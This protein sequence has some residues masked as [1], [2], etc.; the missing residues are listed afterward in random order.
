MELKN[1]VETVESGEQDAILKVL[2]IYNQE[3]SQC[4]TFEDEEREER[5]KM[6]HLLI[7]FLERELQPSC[8]V[9]CLESIRILSRDKS[10]LDPFTTR[11]GLQTLARHAGI[12]YSEELI[13]EVPDLD[14]ILEALKC[15]CNI[16][17]S[18]PRAQEL[19]A[20]ARLVVGLTERIKLYNEKNLPHEVRFFDLRLLF[21]LTAL[22]VDIRQQLAQELRGISLMTDT[23]ELTLGVKWLDPHEVATEGSPPL[24]LP[25]QETER[26]MEILKVL[27]NITFDSSK[28]EVDEGQEDAALYRRLG[29]L[30]R[31]CLMISADGEDRTEEFH[32]HTVNLLGNLP[33]MCL[34]VLL[35]P[36]VR[37]GS[38]EYM[39]VNM[40]AVSVLLDFLERRLDRGHKLK[41]TLTPVLNLLT[42]SARVHRQTRKFLK[43][44]VLPPL[45]DVK[46][47]PEVGNLLRNKLVRLMTH[48]DTDVKHCAAEFLFVLCKESVS[49]FVKYTGYGNAAGLLAARGLMAGGRAE[50]EYSE[51]EDTDTEEYKEAKPNINPVTGRVEEKLP[52]PMEGMTEEQKEYEAMKLVNM[53]DK[54]SRQQ[55]IQP[56]GMTPGGNLTSLENAVH[57]LAEERSSSD[58]DLGLD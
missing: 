44:K 53:F 17:F 26:A 5:K 13:R 50:G 1:V 49:R 20:E 37:P 23:L 31:H 28:K 39:G 40:D 42:E 57:E 52:N 56:M 48:I 6:A 15:L 4:F 46:N 38:L 16:V 10:C 8:Q 2:Q 3:K 25:R 24:P 21:L 30:L 35:T 41:E 22:R 34:D 36:K 45:R 27:F 32:S 18:S 47:R 51:D 12:D 29:A 54:L 58:S 43:A 14:V 19:T 33:L 55:V 11:E 7:K 9:T